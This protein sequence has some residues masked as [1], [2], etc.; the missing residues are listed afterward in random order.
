MISLSY[1]VGAMPFIGEGDGGV[2][3]VCEM[4]NDVASIAQSAF[5]R[6]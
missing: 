3:P 1:R 2:R 6:S 5:M 4:K